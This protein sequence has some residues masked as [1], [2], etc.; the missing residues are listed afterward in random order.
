M[1]V[2]VREKVSYKTSG[3]DQGDEA[4]EPLLKCRK[5]IEEIKTEGESLTRD[6]FGGSL[7]T[8]QVVSGI[9]VA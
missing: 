9:E 5:R 1:V 2:S 8:G 3:E 6:K 7:F 4:I